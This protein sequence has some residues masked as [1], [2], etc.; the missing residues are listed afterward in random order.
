MGRQ[1]RN[2]QFGVDAHSGTERFNLLYSDAFRRADDRRIETER[3]EAIRRR[4]NQLVSVHSAAQLR[5]WTDNEIRQLTHRITRPRRKGCT[6]FNAVE[7]GETSRSS[8]QGPASSSK[9]IDMNSDDELSTALPSARSI[10]P[11]STPRR[12]PRQTASQPNLVKKV[13]NANAQ[14]SPSTPRKGA[15]TN[16]VDQ[17]DKSAVGPLGGKDGTRVNMWAANLVSQAMHPASSASQ[18]NVDVQ[19]CDNCG[20]GFEVDCIYCRKCGERRPRDRR[21]DL[22]G[23]S[24]TGTLSKQLDDNGHSWASDGSDIES[25]AEPD[26][27][28]TRTSPAD[29]K[30]IIDAVRLQQGPGA[31]SGMPQ[32]SH[33]QLAPSSSLLAPTANSR[34][35]N[36]MTATTSSQPHLDKTQPQRISKSSS[37]RGSVVSQ[38]SAASQRSASNRAASAKTHR[39][40][41]TRKSKESSTGVAKRAS[42]PR[43]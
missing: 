30:K 41:S 28:D 7:K 29:I 13:K 15:Y 20:E 21:L 36:S 18:P 23:P 40:A 43:R 10:S 35:R 14:S 24:N 2:G 27:V 38:T 34:V 25:Y 39:A 37:R 32:A 3:Q 16:V 5:G 42:T 22:V 17:H 11:R 4:K 33:S 9:P 8:S 6:W 1:Q 31:T 12:P 19:A 26:L